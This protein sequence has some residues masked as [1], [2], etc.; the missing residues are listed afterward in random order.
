MGTCIGQAIERCRWFALSIFLTYVISS[1]VG[2]VMAHSANATALRQRDR[3]VRTATTSDRITL[4]YKAGNR[5][6]ALALDALANIG[7]AAFPQTVAGLGVVLPYVSVAY[8]GW[9][10][11]IVSVDSR[12][13][14][15]L[16][17]GRGAAYYL[18]VLA[19]QFT[20]FSLVIGA[21]VR[22]GVEM[23][24]LN[25][26]TGLR[27]RQL[28]LPREALVDVAWVYLAA[29]PIFVAASAFEFLSSWN[30]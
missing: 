23:Y 14:S 26:D 2:G 3:V 18:G 9:I 10:G 5:V 27:L 28:K 15:R 20:A 19:L 4:A 25:S 16:S 22:C 29:L 6:R 24:R 21:G 12:H 11:G 17:T 8:Q 13:R 1:A 7:V 30:S